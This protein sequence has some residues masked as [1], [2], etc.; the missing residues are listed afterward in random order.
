MHVL[1]LNLK[2]GDHA[3]TAT[4]HFR[5]SPQPHEGVHAQF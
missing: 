2:H 4:H 1:K 5:K 3:L